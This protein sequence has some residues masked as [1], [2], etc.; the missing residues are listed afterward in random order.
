MLQQIMQYPLWNAVYFGNSV[1]DYAVMIVLFF[2]LLVILES[3]QA[4]VLDHLRRFA[5]KT[6]TEIDDV[7]VKVIGSLRPPFYA[8]L[9]AYLASRTLSMSGFVE[10]IFTAVLVIWITY[11]IIIA[12]E[13]LIDYVTEKR[14]RENGAENAAPMHLVGIMA[15]TL[16]FVFAILTALSNLGVN[17]T[18]LVAGLGIGGVAVA[19]AA[20]NILGDLFSSFAIY[21]DK[22]F[23]VGDAIKMGEITGTV[24]KIGMKT[25]RL[26]A[27]GGE[28]IVIPNREI[29]SARIQNFEKMKE[30]HVVFTFTVPNETDNDALEKIPAWLKEI[31]ENE[32][33]TRFDRAHFKEFGGYSLE[34]ETVYFVTSPDM[35]VHMNARQNIN[36]SIREKFKKEQVSMAYPTQTV[37]VRNG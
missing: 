36:L 9:A 18:S 21:F 20:Q 24:E 4:A 35:L 33:N 34:F 26:R 30:R 17:V 23:V 27:T 2:A 16:I 8:F 22:P 7:L 3:V 32:P 12:I 37:H 5:Q 25:T 14:E 13:I 10:Q 28:E 19:L 15:K 31:V 6:K 11:Q 29:A 1:F